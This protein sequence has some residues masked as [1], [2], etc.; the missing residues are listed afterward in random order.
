[1]SVQGSSS[2]KYSDLFKPPE[3]TSS[4]DSSKESEW[5]VVSHSRGRRRARSTPPS[6][7]SKYSFSKRLFFSCS[8][9]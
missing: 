3:P 4:T 1:M 8:Y 2:L 7:I 6:H 9:G 5:K